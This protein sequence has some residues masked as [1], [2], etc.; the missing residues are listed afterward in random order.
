[1]SAKENAL[2]LFLLV[3]LLSAAETT[4]N[5]ESNAVCRNTKQNSICEKEKAREFMKFIF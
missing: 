5:F 4:M 3:T 2:L 1:M